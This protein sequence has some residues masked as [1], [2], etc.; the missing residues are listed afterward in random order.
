MEHVQLYRN[1]WCMLALDG[2]N[3]Y[4]DKLFC[5]DELFLKVCDRSPGLFSKILCREIQSQ[6]IPVDKGNKKLFHDE[7]NF[8]TVTIEE[9]MINPLWPKVMPR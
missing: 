8:L 7:H 5:I 9:S 1:E 3:G 2:E 6:H 4:D